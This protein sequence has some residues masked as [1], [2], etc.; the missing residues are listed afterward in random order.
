LKVAVP[1]LPEAVTTNVSAAP[2]TAGVTLTE[3]NT[4]DV[5]VAEVPVIPAVPL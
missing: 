5:N 1:L 3:L 2:A 4:P